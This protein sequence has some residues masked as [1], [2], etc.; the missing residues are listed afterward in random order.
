MNADQ[1]DE[2]L[3]TEGESVRNGVPLLPPKPGARQVGLEQVNRLRDEDDL[4]PTLEPQK[5]RR[6][7]LAREC[8]KLDKAAER[9]AAE[10]LLVGE[11]QWPEY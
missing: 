8:A 1:R 5:L 7:R 3:L 6:V 2:N 10:E 4:A 11:T 9:A